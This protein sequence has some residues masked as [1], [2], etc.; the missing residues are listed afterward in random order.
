MAI[1]KAKIM[2][3]HGINGNINMYKASINVNGNNNIN[4]ENNVMA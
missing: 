4:N 1:M 3:Y 2:A